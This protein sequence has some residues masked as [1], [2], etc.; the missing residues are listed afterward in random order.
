MGSE[1]KKEDEAK[2]SEKTPVWSHVMFGA[3]TVGMIASIALLGFW[4]ENR[5]AELGIIVAACAAGMAL[6]RVDRLTSFKAAGVE[7]QLREAK[8]VVE[9]A[10]ASA[11]H[12]RAAAT[13]LISMNLATVAAEG[14]WGTSPEVVKVD[15]KR[16]AVSMLRQLGVNEKEIAACT[17][18][19]DEVLKFRHVA[20]L[21]EAVIADLAEAENGVRKLEVTS[22][23]D[24]FA[25]WTSRY[26]APASAIRKHLEKTGVSGPRIE[27]ALQDLE[28]YEERGDL[29]RPEIWR[30]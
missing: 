30:K 4:K 21:K 28:H 22:Q 26:T 10:Y 11:E 1:T 14:L 8:R 18:A 16:E 24:N 15:R 3:F 6:S 2:P 9:T 25:D 13:S 20:R 19:F 12:L 7:F 17:A 23:L 27:E 29:R 5:A